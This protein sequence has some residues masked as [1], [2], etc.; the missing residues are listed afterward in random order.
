MKPPHL[1]M[2]CAAALSLAVGATN[3]DEGKDES[4]KGKEREKHYSEKDR[5]DKQHRKD[6]RRDSYFHEYG[7]TQLN[8]PP[9]HYPAPGECR[10]WYPDRPPGHQPPPGKCSPVP[11]GAWVIRHPHDD[12]GHVHVT[13]YEPGRPGAILVIGEF[14]IASGTFVRIVWEP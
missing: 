9:G 3:A 14:Q 13:V 4:G 6:G 5:K 2:L 8:I 11:A 1:Q 7:Y 12:P 10:I